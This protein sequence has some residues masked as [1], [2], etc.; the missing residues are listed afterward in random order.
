MFFELL[1]N[2]DDASSAN[3]VSLKVQSKGDY[4]IITHDGFAFSKND[5]DSIT[6]AAKSTKSSNKKKTGYKGIGFK[7]VF[8]NSDAVFIKSGGYSFAFDKSNPDYSDF[9]TF[10]YTVNDLKTDQEK[11]EFRN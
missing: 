3:G 2:A 4:L 11:I 1:Q 8:T 10:Y 7:S 9:E 6:S 5:F